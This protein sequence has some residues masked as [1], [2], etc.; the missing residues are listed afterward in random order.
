[1]LWLGTQHQVDLVHTCG[2][3]TY[4][5]EGESAFSD[6]RVSF[7][8]RFLELYKD[9][10]T[11]INSLLERAQR[12]GMIRGTGYAEVVGHASCRQDQII[13]GY[14]QV[15][16]KDC[17]GIE[18]YV[19]DLCHEEVGISNFTEDASNRLGYVV[20]SK[21]RGAYLIKQREKGVVV[22]AVNKGDVNGSM[23]EGLSS[24]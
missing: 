22:I 10:I 21:L 4:Y 2:A 8:Y 5:R 1:M 15:V 18:I 9:V 14:A 12:K 3:T 24:P 6:F 17:L 20:W 11:Q 23:A 7:I 16:G 19:G 13:V